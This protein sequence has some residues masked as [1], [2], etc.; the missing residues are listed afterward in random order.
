[1][2]IE[3][4]EYDAYEAEIIEAY[5]AK[6]REKRQTDHRTLR[7]GRVDGRER[8]R[9]KPRSASTRVTG[10]H[11]KMKIPLEIE[12]DDEQGLRDLIAF[13]EEIVQSLRSQQKGNGADSD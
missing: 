5:E 12:V 9:P 13:L 1:M 7:C 4:M 11:M 10:C 3:P 2:S 8:L 6:L